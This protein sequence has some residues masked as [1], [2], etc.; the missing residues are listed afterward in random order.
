MRLL[1]LGD[2]VGRP[3]RR[4][5]GAV[6]PRMVA[7]EGVHLVVANCENAAGGKGIDADSA[8]EL[9]DAGV[10]VL[11]SG[12]HVWQHGGIVDYMAQNP[13]LLRPLNFPAGVPGIGCTVHSTTR[14]SGPVGV[15]NLI[16]RVF[17]APAD[18]PFRSAERAVEELR[19]KTP[20]IFVD[21][22][23]EAT[24]EKVAMGR[25]LDG[26]VSAVVGSHTHV[27]TADESL[28]P[29]GT[30]YLTD[31]G[32]CGPEPSVLGVKTEQVLRRFLTQMPTRFEVAAGPVLVQGALIDVDAASGR[33]TA[34][35]R[36]QERVTP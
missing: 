28:L 23:G 8:E 29:G 27:Q 14:G 5:I 6:L 16:G 15:I 10:D 36:V 7:R 22:H 32:M 3:G 34:I 12:N 24:S 26:K 31:A 11:T 25:F 2:V 4:A 20:V 1:F 19:A 9:H 35:R 33:A 17:M 18:C 13:R 30:A 21:M